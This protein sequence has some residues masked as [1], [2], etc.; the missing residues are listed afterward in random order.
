MN[1]SQ[2]YRQIA[3]EVFVRYD[4]DKDSFELFTLRTF[5]NNINNERVKNKKDEREE[6][7]IVKKNVK[8]EALKEIVKDLEEAIF[9][10]NDNN[11]NNDNEE[12]K[13]AKE[14]DRRFKNLISKKRRE[15][16]RE[17]LKES[18][19]SNPQDRVN[20]LR[21]KLNNLP[22]TSSDNN[23]DREDNKISDFVDKEVSKEKVSKA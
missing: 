14:L 1:N 6:F 2:L 8:S 11:D 17:Y 18:E 20:A 7:K 9:G 21:K 13:K 10:D 15:A 19:D 22:K 4:R 23:D 16:L 12:L 3:P 5:I